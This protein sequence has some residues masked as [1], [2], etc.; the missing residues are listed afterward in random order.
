MASGITAFI[1]FAILFIAGL[2]IKYFTILAAISF[3]VL[4]LILLMRI[5]VNCAVTRWLGRYYFEIYVMQG[6]SLLLFHSDLIYIENKW[7]YVL[8]CTLTTLLL[9]V[10]IHP[11]FHF[12]SSMIKG[13][14]TT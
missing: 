3:V 11:I 10:V 7:L 13:K 14:K 9:A 1:A 8:V 12:I 6:I 2:M 4:V 5:P